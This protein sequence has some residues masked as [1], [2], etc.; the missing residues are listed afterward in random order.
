MSNEPTEQTDPVKPTDDRLLQAIAKLT[1]VMELAVVTLDRHARLLDRSQAQRAV[2]A[3]DGLVTV[4]RHA[5]G[6]HVV[7]VR[8]TTEATKAVKAQ[9]EAATRPAGEDEWATY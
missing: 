1:H 8:D 3:V 5:D 7:T 4:K 6:S 9:V 2:D